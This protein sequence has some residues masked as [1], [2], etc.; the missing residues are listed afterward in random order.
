MVLLASRLAMSS[1]GG[2]VARVDGWE[3]VRGIAR[4]VDDLVLPGMWFGATV[5]S[6]IAHGRIDRIVFDPAFDWSQVVVVTAADIPGENTIFL[7]DKEQPALAAGHVDHCAEAVVLVAAPTRELARQA[8]AHVRLELTPLPAILDLADATQEFKSLEIRKGDV[9]TV[10]AASDV[11]VVES[12]SRTGAQEQ[13]YIEPQGMIASP[14]EGGGVTV[15]GSLQCPF[16]VHRALVMLL[17]A[18]S[19]EVVVVQAVTG[20]AFGG[21]EEYPSM[22]AG[23]AAL[24]ALKARRP[25]KMVY[26]R[27]EDIAATTKRHPSLVRHRSAVSPDG[28]LLALD[29][30]ITLDAGAY[31][32]LSKVVL[33]R[34]TIHAAGP[35]RC[36]A[37]RVRSRAMRTHTPPHGAFRGFGAPQSLFALEMQVET[38]AKRLSRD[39]VELRRAWLLRDGDTTSTGQP[40]TCAAGRE[41]LDDALSRLASRPSPPVKPGRRRGRGVSVYMHGAGFTGSGEERIKG[42]AAVGVAQ[43]GVFEVLSGST[44][45]GQGTNTIFAQLAADAL[46]V[47]C[48]SVRIA[49]PDT[50]RVP[51]SGPTVASRT[52]MVMGRVVE[53]CAREVRAQLEAWA[54]DNDLPASDRVALAVER[55]RRAGPLTIERVYASPPGIRWDDQ[56]FSGDAYPVYAWGA[57]VAEVDVDPDTGEV[58]VVRLVAAADAG[59][60]VHP[61]LAEGQIEGGAVQGLGFAL[62]EEVKYKDG[63]VWNDRLATYIIPTSVDVPVVET[64]LCE[65]PFPY[66]PGGGAKGI[67]EMPIDGPA[68]AIVAAVA[69]AIGKLVTEVPLTPEKILAAIEETP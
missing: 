8:V 43:D 2:R 28:R 49:T 23:H 47:P 20:G 62:L 39:P 58:E 18:P 46:G 1:V 60:V 24:L 56:T 57:N 44:E 36:D 52:C 48:E 12:T 66:G 51:D 55:A 10:F 64:V 38:I 34:A 9:D 22:L 14:R 37:V 4:Y 11:I 5:R 3:K 53:E 21:K 40:V 33:S 25:I 16:Y 35:Y 19:D 41:V 59:R 61:V 65:T 29:I 27:Q 31:P 17:G 68:P 54:A 67:G 7:Y 45:M 26:D 42:R 15:V 63:R 69:Q 32:T 50:S 6:P 30:D 13:L